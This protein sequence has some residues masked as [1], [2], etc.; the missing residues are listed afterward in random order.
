MT[1]SSTGAR[2]LCGNALQS[3][4]C[5][6]KEQEERKKK[7]NARARR[8]VSTN[9][10]G[11]AGFTAKALILR[12]GYRNMFRA[13]VYNAQNENYE[14]KMRTVSKRF[15]GNVLREIMFFCR[16]EG[17]FVCILYPRLPDM[18]A[19]ARL[20]GASAAAAHTQRINKR[21]VYT[22]TNA[23]DH[24]FELNSNINE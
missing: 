19:P 8:M 6:L 21:F 17:E 14:R 22:Y 1:L 12:W 4:L 3:L 5:A 23:P 2:K 20:L 9:T 11:R 18:Y 10:H 13:S 16:S 15:P 7:R 24:R